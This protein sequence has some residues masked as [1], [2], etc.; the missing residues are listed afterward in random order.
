MNRCATI[1]F[2]LLA[3]VLAACETRRIEY[4]KRPAWV[5]SM[6]KDAPSSTITE[7]GTEIRWIDDRSGE[8]QG[9]EQRIGGEQVRIRTDHEDGSVELRNVVPMHLVVNLLECMRRGE[10]RVIYDQLIAVEKRTWYDERGESGFE[11]FQAWFERNRKDIGSMLNRMQAGKVYG[12]VAVT[13]G[14]RRGTVALRPSVAYDFRLKAID[15]V[16]ED[17]DWKLLDIR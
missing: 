16:R 6:S 15:V 10:Y 11:E 13:T 5:R 9:F 4:R 1:L 3:V 14:E 2:L 12:E 8:L 17:G 7:D